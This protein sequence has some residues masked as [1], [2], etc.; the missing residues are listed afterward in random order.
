[1]M[2][3]VNDTKTRIFVTAAGRGFS[4]SRARSIS[5]FSQEESRGRIF[6]RVQKF[7]PLTQLIALLVMAPALYVLV[8]YILCLSL[9]F[10]SI[11]AAI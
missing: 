6:V 2:I 8:D 5:T 9:L 11:Q 10:L 7:S 4:T 1:V 3:T